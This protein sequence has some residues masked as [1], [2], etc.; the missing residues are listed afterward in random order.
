MRHTPSRALGWALL[1]FSFRPLQLNETMRF[2][3]CRSDPFRLA[4]SAR[5]DT[6]SSAHPPPSLTR[7]PSHHPSHPIC[8][9]DEQ[10]TAWGRMARMIGG[11]VYDEH[12]NVSRHAWA[13]WRGSDTG[14]LS[15][16]CQTTPVLVIARRH[17]SLCCALAGAPS[18]HWA[19]PWCSMDLRNLPRRPT[20]LYS[21]TPIH[22][23][24]RHARF[25]LV[26]PTQD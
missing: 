15:D 24:S 10:S 5:L 3:G 12:W 13:R 26:P 9:F 17:K 1:L 23:H 22:P 4:L 16:L 21:L 20:R 7:T 2:G 18:R 8:F 25:A 19:I 11:R 6:S 14:R